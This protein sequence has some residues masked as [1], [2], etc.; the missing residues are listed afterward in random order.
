MEGLLLVNAATG[1]AR[2]GG[3]DAALHGVNLWREDRT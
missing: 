1:R 3:G 2:E